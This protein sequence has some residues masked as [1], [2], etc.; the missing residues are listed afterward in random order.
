[1]LQRRILDLTSKE[2]TLLQERQKLE[3]ERDSLQF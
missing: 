3:S 1:M 2:S